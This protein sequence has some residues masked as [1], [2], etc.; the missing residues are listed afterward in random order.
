MNIPTLLLKLPRDK[1]AYRLK[2]R[3]KIEP[4]PRA[5]RLDRE[6]VRVAERFVDDMHKQGW[7]HVS[8]YGFTMKGPFPYVAPV[9]IH[10]PRVPS[11]REMLRGVAQGARYLDKGGTVAGAMPVLDAT[12][13]WEFELQATFTRT[14]ILT[15]VADRHE[16]RGA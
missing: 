4:Y 13:W 3:F 11:A 1:R 10:T 14:E 7:E 5:D 2:C 9:T 8:Q 16:E 12:E 15:E 6:K